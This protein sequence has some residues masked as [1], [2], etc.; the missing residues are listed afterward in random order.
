M[1]NPFPIQFSANR[2]GFG[3]SI[4]CGLV[5]T[6]CTSLGSETTT[7]RKGP[8]QSLITGPYFL[9]TLFKY[10]NNSV[11]KESKLCNKSK[12]EL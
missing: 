1:N 11:F 2:Y 4:V 8:T 7:H 6:N 9:K 12:K 5:V 10:S 3:F